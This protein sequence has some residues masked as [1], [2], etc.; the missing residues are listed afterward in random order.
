[1]NRRVL[2]GRISG[3]QGLKGE[4]RIAAYTVE[5]ADIA[6]YGSLTDEIGGQ[7]FEILSVRQGR[8]RAI[9]A[10]LA[11][12]SDRN[13]AGL[14]TGTNLYVPREAFPPAAA[15][16]YYYSDLSGLAAFSP[17]GETIGEIVSV[18]NF[19]AGDLLELRS[20]QGGRT[21]FIPFND[22]HVPEVD[23]SS[24]RIIIAKPIYERGEAAGSE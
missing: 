4:V 8:N 12:V 17:D 18:Q 14:L 13:A 3:A 15:G 7:S 2:I 5:P 10:R 11:G 6:A 22:A 23:L 24:G 21:E 16:E 20:A 1:M 9:I 19:G